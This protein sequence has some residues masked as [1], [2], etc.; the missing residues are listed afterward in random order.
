MEH[1][2]TA[3]ATATAA[4]VSAVPPVVLQ[5]Q[6]PPPAGSFNP[7]NASPRRP[8]RGPPPRVPGTPRGTMVYNT[9]TQQQ[10]QQPQQQT[11]TTTLPLNHLSPVGGLSAPNTPIASPVGSPSF[12]S[13]PL[14]PILTTT[15]STPPLAHQ[16]QTRTSSSQKPP[17]PRSY[18]DTTN[19]D[20]L[21]PASAHFNAVHFESEL[22]ALL[23]RNDFAVLHAACAAAEKGR[24]TEAR[25]FVIAVI[26]CFNAAVA[27]ASVDNTNTTNN[28]NDND[29]ALLLELLKS[30][31]HK[32]VQMNAIPDD[33]TALFRDN[34]YIN[35]LLS[36]SLT[37][38]ARPYLLSVLAPPLQNL[39]E[40][41]PPVEIDPSRL[42]PD[43]DLNTNVNNLTES[44]VSFVERI[45]HSLPDM[46][47]F[48]RALCEHLQVC[49]ADWYKNDPVT[50]RSTAPTAGLLFLRFFCVAIFSPTDIIE[51]RPTQQSTR[52]LILI[53]KILQ[54]LANGLTFGA[55]AE[56]Y[57]ERLNPFLL[58]YN[59]PL[60][61]FFKQASAPVSGAAGR[62]TNNFTQTT[63]IIPRGDIH[64]SSDVNPHAAR[65]SAKLHEL[66]EQIKEE[67][68]QKGHKEDIGRFTEYLRHWPAPAPALTAATTPTSPT[69]AD[70]KK[71]ATYLGSP[72]PAASSRKHRFPFSGASK[73]IP[74]IR[75]KERKDSRDDSADFATSPS[76]KG[77]TDGDASAISSANLEDLQIVLQQ[78]VDKRKRLDEKIAQVEKFIA[79]EKKVIANSKKS[80][81]GSA[82]NTSTTPAT[83]AP[84]PAVYV[85]SVSGTT[86]SMP[87][88]WRKTDMALPGPPGPFPVA[89]L[90]APR[91]AAPAPPVSTAA[92][93]ATTAT[94]TD[95]TKDVDVQHIPTSIPTSTLSTVVESQPQQPQQP[96]KPQSPREPSLPK[97]TDQPPRPPASAPE[98][99]PNPVVSPPSTSTPSPA[100]ANI[101]AT[102]ATNATTNIATTT[103]TNTAA[104]ANHTDPQPHGGP[105]AASDSSISDPSA[106]ATGDG[107]ANPAAPQRPPKPKTP[108]SRPVGTLPRRQGPGSS[109]TMIVR[110]AGPTLGSGTGSGS[111]RALPT[112]PQKQL[113]SPALDTTPITTAPHTT[114]APTTTPEVGG[115]P[116]PTPTPKS[117][118]SR[119][120]VALRGA[121]PQTTDSLPSATTSQSTMS[122]LLDESLSPRKSRR[123]SRVIS[124]GS[125]PQFKAGSSLEAIN[126]AMPTAVAGGGQQQQQQQQPVATPSS[127]PG[128]GNG[129]ASV[130]DN[131]PPSATPLDSG[132]DGGEPLDSVNTRPINFDYLDRVLPEAPRELDLDGVVLHARQ[133]TSGLIVK[134]KKVRFKV[135]KESFVGCEFVDWLLIRYESRVPSRAEAVRVGQKLIDRRLI[136][137]ITED[138]K[139]FADKKVF[140]KF[141]DEITLPPALTEA[142]N[143][144]IDSGALGTPGLFTIPGSKKEL[145][146][147]K[148]QVDKGR[149][150]EW[151]KLSPI[152]I[153]DFIKTSLSELP[154][155]LLTFDM[156]SA[157]IAL[158]DL[159]H[160]PEDFIIAARPLLNQLPAPNIRVLRSILYMCDQIVVA[161]CADSPGNNSNNNG[162]QSAQ[163]K[164]RLTLASILGPSILAGDSSDCVQNILDIQAC[165]S[166]VDALITNHTSLFD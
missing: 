80:N 76:G 135:H 61:E 134:P 65:I 41:S 34:N 72:N 154:E 3:T 14:T 43:E 15:P 62:P 115:A 123:L 39:I 9:A 45:L 143:S 162:N 91:R 5:A 27:A 37:H 131:I 144:I 164:L 69:A 17:S 157:F 140:Y 46:P 63:F 150:V 73:M 160:I 90:N 163:Q 92:T 21:T 133:P 42:G 100:S 148:A 82:S 116:N 126:A 95:T 118:G 7:G 114:A 38:T 53:A 99:Q 49:V 64:K 74:S 60:Q 145:N 8:P 149:K 98:P 136:A 121:S 125:F 137:H 151:K 79:E 141:C 55:N 93:T 19:N 16:Q 122:T 22:F 77:E 106:P 13:S 108:I 28:T 119:A 4:P 97:P 146:E 117:F 112:P 156:H 68:D 6:S 58:K 57:M 10:P 129:I 31:I 26:E 111:V 67:L 153:A 105:T 139:G 75:K 88:G 29:H 101:T 166:V 96:Q 83:N 165:N 89:T 36:I 12:P 30:A 147:F 54:M 81:V 113:S 130:A 158:K 66:E 128:I 84:T 23:I 71:R 152:L 85:P 44:C 47:V 59:A 24:G 155:P 86:I 107:V 103:T 127:G 32:E 124:E 51:Q 104:D 1:T 56:A 50:S 35:R 11:P 102:T 142:I 110:S 138:G 2:A 70:L 48:I 20:T 161:A 25:A 159:L 132:S 78:L 18:D 33:A 94:T 120:T 87:T 109:G 40:K 52:G